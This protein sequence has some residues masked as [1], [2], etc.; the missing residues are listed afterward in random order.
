MT[1]RP[2][3]LSWSRPWSSPVLRVLVVVMYLLTV[4]AAASVLSHMA[5]PGT[6]LSRDL[7]ITATVA[8][9]VFVVAA[10]WGAL[11]GVVNRT[12]LRLSDG[13]LTVTHHPLP[14]PG[15]R[16]FRPADIEAVTVHEDRSSEED[17]PDVVSDSVLVRV[18]GTFARTLV[19]G[20]SERSEAEYIR[21]RVLAG[22][23]NDGQLE[24]I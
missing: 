3:V 7:R 4:G 6:T 2:D 20:L 22:R 11:A 16:R 12:T 18:Q 23:P 24:G 17:G 21:Q 8:G 15:G 19:E 13:W 10:T 1:V 9:W 14:W 5:D